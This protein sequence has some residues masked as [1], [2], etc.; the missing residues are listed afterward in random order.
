MVVD[1]PLLRV[2]CCWGTTALRVV[3]RL[4]A[5]AKMEVS[6]AAFHA[7]GHGIAAVDYEVVSGQF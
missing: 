6:A 5:T 7:L 3:D 1:V 4:F 2:G